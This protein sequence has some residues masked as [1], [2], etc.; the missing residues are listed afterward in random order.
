MKKI[1]TSA[2]ALALVATPLL[3]QRAEAALGFITGN[4][5]LIIVGAVAAAVDSAFVVSCVN[6]PHFRHCREGFAIGTVGL[7]GLLLLDGEY[8][9]AAAFSPLSI[10]GAQKLGLTSAQADAYNHE[11]AEIN[12]IRQDLLSDVLVRTDAGAKVAGSEIHG[13]WLEARDAGMISADA[14]VALEKVSAQVGERLK[15]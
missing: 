15:K 9:Q 10:E 8:G 3:P 2:L 5:P 6:G 7:I 13:R 4:A 1:V 11:L 14:F 12:A